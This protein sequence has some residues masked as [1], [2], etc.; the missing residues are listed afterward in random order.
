[1]VVRGRGWHG[2]R[3][4]TEKRSRISFDR[5]CFPL[6]TVLFS[7]PVSPSS[8]EHMSL[9]QMSATFFV[10]S[11]K[12]VR[13]EESQTCETVVTLNFTFPRSLIYT[14]YVFLTDVGESSLTTSTLSS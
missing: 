2:S 9:Q 5:F 1:M 8:Y 14:L 11:L 6:P 10:S 3:V 7:L 12:S 4:G 13:F